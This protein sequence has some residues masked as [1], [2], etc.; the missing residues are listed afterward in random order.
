MS[1]SFVRERAGAFVAGLRAAALP[2]FFFGA[3]VLAAVLARGAAFFVFAPPFFDLAGFAWTGADFP[4][5]ASAVS[6]FIAVVLLSPAGGAGSPSGL[7]S[8]LRAT[9]SA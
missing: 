1:V 6:V 5:V 9:A 4:A 2:A 3:A 8:A 7:A